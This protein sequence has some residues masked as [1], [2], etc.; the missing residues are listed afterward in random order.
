MAWV[1]TDERA[2]CHP[3]FFRA[4]FQAFG[5]WS[6]GLGYCNELLTNGFIPIRDLELVF[7]GAI[8][9]DREAAIESLVRE[10]SLHTVSK[11]GR[12]ECPTSAWCRR[13]PHRES[14]Y[15]MHDYLDYQPSRKQAEMLR[16]VRLHAARK[17]GEKSAKVRNQV[18]STKPQPTRPTPY[19]T[20]PARTVPKEKPTTAVAPASDDTWLK[21]LEASQTYQGIDVRNELGKCRKWCAEHGVGSVSRRRL[22]NWLNRAERPIRTANGVPPGALP[23]KVEASLPAIQRFVERRSQT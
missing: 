10:G 2:R 22:V 20:V 18:G 7:P 16:R 3:K 8:P 4:G 6:A 19:R 12:V 5:W 23:A 15:L 1:K 14:G 17:G 13:F 21:D 11:G 9:A